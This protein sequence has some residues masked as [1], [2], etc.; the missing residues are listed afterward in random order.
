MKTLLSL[1]SLTIVLAA[2]AQS[3]LLVTGPAIELEPVESA[4]TYHTPAYHSNI[5]KVLFSKIKD[6]F[7]FQFLSLPSSSPERLLSVCKTSEENYYGQTLAPERQIW[8]Y[9]GDVTNIN[10]LTKTKILPKRLVEKACRVWEDM[11][12][13]TRYQGRN[14]ILDGIGYVFL[15]EV[16]IKNGYEPTLTG[17]SYNPEEG[18]RPR[19]LADIGGLLYR[20]VNCS[21]E[22]EQNLEREI[23]GLLAKLEAAVKE[24]EKASN[25]ASQAIGAPGPLPG[26]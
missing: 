18:T 6:P 23:L 16:K 7:K 21:K 3:D 19:L 5:R 9:D 8:N 17:E 13:R 12:I 10:V 1:L 2:K 14:V 26:R 15:C 11:L 24:A 20:Y 4:L 22:E 25:K